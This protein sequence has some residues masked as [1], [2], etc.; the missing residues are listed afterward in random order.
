MV[1]SELVVGLAQVA[2]RE[3]LVGFTYGLELLVC[4]WV[5]GVLVWE[6]QQV[7]DTGLMRC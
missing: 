3:D 6:P 1:F 5:V 4:T 7:L 2:V